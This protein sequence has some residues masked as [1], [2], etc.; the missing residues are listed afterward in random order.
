MEGQYRICQKCKCG[1]HC[2][3]CECPT[4]Q[5]NEVCETCDCKQELPSTFV[6]R[7]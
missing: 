7:N 2:Y 3:D 5:I 1:C 4:C 6:K